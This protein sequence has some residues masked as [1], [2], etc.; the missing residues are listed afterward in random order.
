MANILS[1]FR[2]ADAKHLGFD[3]LP[4]VSMVRCGLDIDCFG[5]N[6]PRPKA[7]GFI[8][9]L[10]YCSHEEHHKPIRRWSVDWRPEQNKGTVI[11]RLGDFRLGFF[12]KSKAA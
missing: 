10:V 11:L 8:L 4:V 5:I 2:S 9:S 6:Q 1:Q 3:F 7:T 12:I